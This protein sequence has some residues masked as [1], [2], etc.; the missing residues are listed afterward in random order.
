[1]SEET[2]VI[3]LGCRLNTYESEV[4]RQ[5]AEQAGLKEALVINTCAVTGEAVRQARQTIRKLRKSNPDATLIVTGCAAQVEPETFAAMPEV[6][7]VIGNAEKLQLNSFLPE[8]DHP[9]VQVSDI[10]EVRE[11]AHHLI[12]GFEGHTRAFLEV[13]QGCDHRCTFCIIPFGRGPNR[14][15]PMGEIVERVRTLV[16]AGYREVVLTGVD[17]TSYGPDLPGSP[18]FG[19]M[20]K[21]LLKAVPDLPR[22]RLSSLDPAA[23]D[24]DLLDVIAHEPRL[25]GHFHLS[26]QS[27]DD[28]VLKRMKRRHLAADAIQLC[29]TI[30][31]LRP[32]AVFGADII[33][34]FP[35]ETDEMHQNTLATLTACDVTFIHVFPYSART[36]T[37]AE[38]MPQVTGDVR[39]ARAAEIRALGEANLQA[40]LQSRLGQ[41]LEVLV[42]KD[43]QGHCAHYCPVR[44]TS[45]VD[46]GHIVC[47]EA[48][49]VENG[50]L[51]AEKVGA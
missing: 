11:T 42:E 13:Q 14:S 10:M 12:D 28:M 44:L 45:P 20:V 2:R 19:Q 7:R 48:K 24:K 41:R 40:F 30:R 33:A 18:P 43:N 22:L 23:I 27:G 51:I 32:D 6:D 46:A 49:S 5:N 17:V 26:L 50:V 3:T 39:K 34:G 21:R 9:R 47:A 31:R 36:G 38:K 35:T 8:A 15:V 16:K 37:P 4:M 29:E 25:L 1:M